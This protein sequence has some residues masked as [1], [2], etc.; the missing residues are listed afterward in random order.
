MT[1]RGVGPLISV[2]SAPDGNPYQ[3]RAARIQALVLSGRYR[4]ERLFR[5]WSSNKNGF[6]LLL[7]C[8]NLQL[9]EDIEHFIVRCT[10]LTEVR[11]R[12]FR[13]TEEYVREKPVLKQLC[14]AYLQP[15][16]P[17]LYIQFLLDCS[18][19]PLVISAVQ[20]HG[21]DVHFHLFR[22]SRTWCRSLHVARL[23]L[24]GCS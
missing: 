12:L 15:A 14:D 6:C 7:L 23:K 18:V 13:Y 16:N 5:F 1:G 11:R 2:F 20:L 19:L 22:I 10:A 24:L 17:T 3:A 4:T 8:N 21:Q 9:F